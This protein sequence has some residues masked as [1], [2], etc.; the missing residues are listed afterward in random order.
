[1][2]PNDYTGALVIQDESGTFVYMLFSDGSLEDY[3]YL[4]AN[5]FDDAEEEV[6]QMFDEDEVPEIELDEEGILTDYIDAMLDEERIYDGSPN[7]GSL[8]DY[9]EDDE[10]YDGSLASYYSDPNHG[11]D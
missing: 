3:Q 1:M 4:V 2:N 11:P 10:D 9:G 5:S 6:R 7:F 8:E